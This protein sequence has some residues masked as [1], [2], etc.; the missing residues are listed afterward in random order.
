MRERSDERVAL[1]DRGRRR[2]GRGREDQ[3][4]VGPETETGCVFGR[5][6]VCPCDGRLCAVGAESEGSSG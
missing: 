1:E 5:V 3:G 4:E 2:V 6:V